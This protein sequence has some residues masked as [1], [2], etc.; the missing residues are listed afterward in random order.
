MEKEE[1]KHIRKG[2]EARTRQKEVGP[3]E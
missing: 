2:E 1:R 3:G